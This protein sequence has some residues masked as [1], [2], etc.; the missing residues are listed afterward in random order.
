MQE[1]KKR[2][3][4]VDGYILEDEVI[5]RDDAVF[6]AVLMEERKDTEAY[7]VTG[8]MK[9]S[10]VRPYIVTPKEMLDIVKVVE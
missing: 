4:F 8:N 10:P 9:H 3:V 2:A 5:D 1:L 6:Y 7:L